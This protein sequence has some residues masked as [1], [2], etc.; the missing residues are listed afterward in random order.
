MTN[1]FPATSNNTALGWERALFEG[2]TIP[3]RPMDCSGASNKESLEEFLVDQCCVTAGIMDMQQSTDVGEEV[4]LTPPS[5]PPQSPKAFKAAAKSPPQSPKSPPASPKSPK[6]PRSPRSPPKSPKSPRSQASSSDDADQ[7]GDNLQLLPSL[8]SSKANA[9]AEELDQLD[10]DKDFDVFD[11]SEEIDNNTNAKEKKEDKAP[12]TL[13]EVDK[14]LEYWTTRLEREEVYSRRYKP[15]PE[16]RRELTALEQQLQYSNN[17]SSNATALMR[18]WWMTWMGGLTDVTT[19]NDED[20][21]GVTSLPATVQAM[22]SSTDTTATSSQPKSIVLKRGRVH[23]TVTDAAKTSRASST[24]SNAPSLSEVETD[25]NN[26]IDDAE[27]ELILLTHGLLVVQHHRGNSSNPLLWTSRTTPRLIV[28]QALPWPAVHHVAPDP[29]SPQRAWRLVLRS[30][31]DNDDDDNYKPPTL[32]WTFTCPHAVQQQAWLDAMER[33]LIQHALHAGMAPL[34]LG[35]QYRLVY[36]P[37]FTL[38]VQGH[39]DGLSL[40]TLRD[41]DNDEWDRLD[42]YNEYAPLHVSVVV[43]YCDGI[44]VTYA[45]TSLALWFICLLA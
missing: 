27:V 1:G 8:S 42:E 34:T 41:K 39:D 17:A 45:L 15:T 32:Y 20:D 37:A 5:S 21:K 31:N 40:K 30:A 44:R 3:W 19:S 26:D 36:R 43:E 35:W 6:S 25:S 29:Q 33:V 12:P 23:W 24:H 38:A 4:V 10:I 9:L 14:P 2:P 7:G 18:S 13:L 28:Q 16:E 22:L 11:K